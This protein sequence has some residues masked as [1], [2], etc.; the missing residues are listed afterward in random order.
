METVSIV[1]YMPAKPTAVPDKAKISEL[2]FQTGLSIADYARMV[3][4]RPVDIY[5]I[6]GKAP[7]PHNVVLIKKIANGLGL[8]ARDIS[9]WPHPDF[10][11]DAPKALAS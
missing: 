8:E 11:W 6:T 10:N 1:R 9:D 3:G 4:C 5:E 7:R 2:I